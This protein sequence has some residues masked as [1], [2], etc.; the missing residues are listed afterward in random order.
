MALLGAFTL[1]ARRAPLRIL[2]APVA[3]VTL[4][5]ALGYGLTR[6]R[7]PAEISIVILAAVGLSRALDRWRPTPTRSSPGAST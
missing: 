5:S 7:H 4:T 6:F 2:M 3:L 1:R